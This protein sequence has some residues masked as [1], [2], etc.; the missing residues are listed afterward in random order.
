MAELGMV[1]ADVAVE[2]HRLNK[3]IVDDM[4]STS[5]QTVKESQDNVKEAEMEQDV[6]KE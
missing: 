5:Q 6:V 1:L 3:K 4:V 2:V